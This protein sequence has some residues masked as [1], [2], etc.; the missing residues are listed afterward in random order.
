MS[1]AE[2]LL[3]VNASN[4]A[5]IET[6]H[7]VKQLNPNQVNTQGNLSCNNNKSTQLRNSI[8]ISKYGE[9]LYLH[10]TIDQLEFQLN[11]LKKKDNNI[12]ITKPIFSNSS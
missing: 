2:I 12:Y 6:N 10:K 11:S 1:R 8:K 7:Q 9:P 3:P 4:S 5:Y